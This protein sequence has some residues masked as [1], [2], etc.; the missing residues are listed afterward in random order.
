[1][2]I[3]KLGINHILGGMRAR[4]SLKRVCQKKKTPSRRRATRRGAN[5]RAVPQPKVGACEKAKMRRMIE[6]RVN[7]CV[8][9]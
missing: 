2:R 1:M 5:T 4:S 7:D 6:A 3:R 8:S 9:K